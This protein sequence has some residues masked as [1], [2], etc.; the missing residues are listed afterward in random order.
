[1]SRGRLSALLVLAA[2]VVAGAVHLWPQSDRRLIETQ[3]D[4]LAAAASVEG[5]ETPL[6]RAASAARMGAFFTDDVIIMIDARSSTIGGRDA[7]VA[8]AAQARAASRTLAVEF[9]D[10]QIA[11]TGPSAATVYTTI[12]VTGAD[13]GGERLVDAREI[14]IECRKVGST[15]LIAR[16]AALRTLERAP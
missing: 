1:L 6:M 2:A 14:M 13:P 15:W 9:D 5:T 12:A 8:L 7:V 10:L 16:V 11:M 4:R 3:L